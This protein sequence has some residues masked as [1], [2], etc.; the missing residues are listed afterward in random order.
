[1]TTPIANLLADRQTTTLFRSERDE[2][3]QTFTDRLN[4]VRKGTKWKPLACRVIAIKT[5]HLSLTELRD[6]E[7]DCQNAKSYSAYFF[8]ALKPKGNDQ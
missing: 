2:L 5:S 4:A 8:W 6:F 7:K 3:V 1:M